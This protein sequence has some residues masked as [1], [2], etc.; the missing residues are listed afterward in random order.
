MAF[1]VTTPASESKVEDT[2]NKKTTHANETGEKG[3]SCRETEIF[4]F[5]RVRFKLFKVAD[6]LPTTVNTAVVCYRAQSTSAV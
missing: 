2:K 5:I 1:P 3:Y 6:N 4:L